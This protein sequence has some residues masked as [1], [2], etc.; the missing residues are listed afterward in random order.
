MKKTKQSEEQRRSIQDFAIEN[1]NLNCFFEK[2]ETVNG[3]SGM[4]A[5]G[6]FNKIILH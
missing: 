5:E 3:I 4:V 2:D 6:C 1:I